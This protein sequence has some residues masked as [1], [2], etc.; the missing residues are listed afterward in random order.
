[1][2]KGLLAGSP[3]FTQAI[4]LVFT[5][6]ACFLLFMFIGILLAPPILGISITDVIHLLNNGGAM[7]NLHLM[8]YMQT[9]QGIS[10][11]IVPAFFAAYLFS[12]NAPAYLE[13]RQTAPAKWFGAVLLLVVMAVPC[14]NLMASL[15]EMISFP[16]SFSGLEQRLK[17]YEEAAQ[18]TTKLFL[19]VDNIGGMLFNIFMMAVLPALGEDLIFRGVLQKI[20]VRWAGNVHVGIIIAGLMFSLMHM[21]FYGLFPRWLLGVMFGYLLVWGGTLWLPIFAHFV[22]NGMAVISSCL[23]HK[24]IIPEEI[25]FFGST[26]GDIPVTM[27]TAAICAWLLWRMY[28]NRIKKIPVTP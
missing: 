24:G 2:R 3:P 15:N 25:E 22:H 4:M 16:E 6:V 20:L 5:M 14:I 26:W 12:G 7:Q 10:L 8:R 19:E 11:F 13:L 28:R 18:K 23:I 27:I 17:A 9:L 21:Q 1:M